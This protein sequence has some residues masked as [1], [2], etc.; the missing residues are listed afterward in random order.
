M[1]SI[2][3]LNG[4]NWTKSK[5]NNYLIFRLYILQ[6]KP[7]YT[8]SN[9]IKLIRRACM[10]LH[11]RQRVDNARCYIQP[12]SNVFCERH[13][14]KEL[15]EAAAIYILQLVTISLLWPLQYKPF[16]YYPWYIFFY[17][18]DITEILL[19]VALNTTTPYILFHGDTIAWEPS[20]HIVFWFCLSSRIML[21]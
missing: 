6:G 11:T 1:K 20:Q 21:Q 13:V 7:R 9:T 19:K 15:M 4:F 16:R 3:I 10:I 18:H 12:W 17:R 8:C 2:I 5:M 14:L